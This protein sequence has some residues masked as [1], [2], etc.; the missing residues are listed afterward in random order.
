M[1]TINE[2]VNVNA[3]YFRGE[4]Q[5]K[6]FPREIELGTTRYTFHDGLQYLVKQGQ[7]MVKFFD[8]NDGSTT[9]RLRL[10]NNTWTL[11]GTRSTP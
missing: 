7:H 3:F 4:R 1:S 5:L 9:F 2:V 8:M 10:E 11:I 6:S